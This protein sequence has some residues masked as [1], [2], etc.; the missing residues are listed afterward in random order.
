MGNML[1]NII[2]VMLILI[3]ALFGYTRKRCSAAIP[4]YGKLAPHAPSREGWL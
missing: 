4:R 3:A 2:G 1:G